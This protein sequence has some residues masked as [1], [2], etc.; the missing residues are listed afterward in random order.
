MPSREISF[1]DPVVVLRG[2]HKGRVGVYEDDFLNRGR[3]IGVVKFGSPFLTHE[4]HNIVVVSLSKPD[5][6]MLLRRLESL[7]KTIHAFTELLPAEDHVVALLEYYLIESILHGRYTVAKLEKQ[8]DGASIFL[9]H[10]SKDKWFVNRLAVDLTH[11]GHRVWLDEWEI[12]IGESI[13]T[14]IS[15]GLDM[16]DFIAVVLTEHAVASKWVE[17]EWQVKYWDEIEKNKTSVLP[18]LVEDCKIPAL[19]RTRKYA[20]FR[21]D[22]SP[23]LKSV[24]AALEALRRPKGAA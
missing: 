14:K 10:S 17:R 2:E 7:L 13:P 6:S 16:A 11:L 4:E 5:T 21:T 3:R 24:A 18:L 12:H 9:S 22:Y 23:A 15:A 8:T 1:G 20:D 19:L